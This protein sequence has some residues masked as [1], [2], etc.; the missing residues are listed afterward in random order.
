MCRERHGRPYLWGLGAFRQLGVERVLH[1]WRQLGAGCALSLLEQARAV[2][3]HQAV[4]RAVLGAMAFVV[5]LGASGQPT[6]LCAS[7]LH[8][9]LSHSDCDA[10][11]WLGA[12]AGALATLVLLDTAFF[13]VDVG[14]RSANASGQRLAFDTQYRAYILVY[15]SEFQYAKSGNPDYPAMGQ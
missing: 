14:W 8:A 6:R 11:Y 1:E 12:A 4:Q 9:R 13:A 15:T 3:L 7:G 5:E 2:L 10:C